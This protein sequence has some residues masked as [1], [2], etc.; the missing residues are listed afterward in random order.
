MKKKELERWLRKYGWQLLRQGGSHEQW[1][2]GM[3]IISVP[4]HRELKENT[5]RGVM[6]AVMF[7]NSRT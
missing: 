2:D 7:Y 4:R 3:H 5:A 6:K 1:T